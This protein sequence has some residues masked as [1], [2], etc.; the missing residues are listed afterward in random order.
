IRDKDG[1]EV[2]RIHVPD[3]GTVTVVPGD[4]SSTFP[5]PI[6]DPSLKRSQPSRGASSVGAPTAVVPSKSSWTPTPEQQA[7]LDVTA[8]LPAPARVQAV[9]R[10][11]NE[12]NV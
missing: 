5:K 1:N 11:L 9:V 6:E 2:A 8:Q 10:K 12:L 3:G 7:F 4:G